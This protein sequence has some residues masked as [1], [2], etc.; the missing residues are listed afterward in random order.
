[1]KREGK[2]GWAPV[3]KATLTATAAGVGALEDHRIQQTKVPVPNCD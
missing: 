2:Y 1:M 3:V